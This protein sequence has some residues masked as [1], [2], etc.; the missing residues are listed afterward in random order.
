MTCR[1]PNFTKIMEFKCNGSSRGGCTT[2][3]CSR[4][5]FKEKENTFRLQ[6]H[7]LSYT[8]DSCEWT[9]TYGSSSSASVY[10]PIFSKYNFSTPV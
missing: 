4:N 1:I 9:C 8:K 2:F 6:I 3:V 10:L 5:I 7:F